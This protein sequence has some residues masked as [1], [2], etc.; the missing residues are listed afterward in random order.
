MQRVNGSFQLKGVPSELEV[1]F[2]VVSVYNTLMPNAQDAG[3]HFDVVTV[4][5]DEPAL[6]SRRAPFHPDGSQRVPMNTAHCLWCGR[7]FMPRRT[8]GS[9]Q[10]FCS[11]G[12]RQ[13]FWIAARRWTMR[14][15]ETGL[16]SVECLK[17]VR[18]SVHAAPPAFRCDGSMS[19]SERERQTTL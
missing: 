12:H 11:T 5:P 3:P 2:S 14:A 1:T 17:A 4:P 13:A 19:T 7:A 8:G 9:A 15:L 6:S 16:L 18:T 10:R